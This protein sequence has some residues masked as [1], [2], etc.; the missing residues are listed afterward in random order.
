LTELSKFFVP[1]PTWVRPE[2]LSEMTRPMVA[3]RSAAFQEVALGIIA[4]LKQL[5]RTG[6]HAYVATCS[7]TGL[8]EAALINC[9]PRRVLV[10]T[11]GA[12][13]ER[14]M[15]I[16][17]RLGLEVD[18]LE[19]TWGEPVDPE[20][21]ANH[22]AGRRF[23]YDAVTIT[24][25]ETSTGVLNDLQTL[26]SVIQAES[27]DT[28]ILVDAVSSL[29][30]APV[31]F[32]DWGIDVCV[33]SVQKGMALPPGI[34]VFAASERALEAARKKPY[35][36][37]YFDF[38]ELEKNVAAGSVPFTPSIPHYYALARQLDHILRQEGLEHRWARHLAMRDRTLER[39]AAFATLMAQPSH[40]SVSVSALR[41]TQ[42]QPAAILSAMKERG[43]TLGSG[44]GAWKESGF[45]IGHMGDIT[46]EALDQMLDVLAEVAV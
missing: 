18:Q 21:L 26:T 17:E 40:A 10:T 35:R 23:H 31:L 6:Q 14:W 42:K 44:Y 30:A 37:V 43:Y 11:C 15:N 45:R 32:D 29:A 2:I 28:L 33:A 9:V 19:H 24:H 38:L 41:P 20:R 4:D 1:G 34:A 27:R 16:A 7:G 3:H 12:F 25:N 39:T 13:S 36:G 8:L 22:F 46:I 5:F